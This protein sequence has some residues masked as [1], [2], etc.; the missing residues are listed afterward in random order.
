MPTTPRDPAA[1]KRTTRADDA[2]GVPRKRRSYVPAAQAQELLLVTTIRLARELPLDQVTA[3]RIASEAGLDPSTIPRNFGSMHSLFVAVCRRL[4]ADAFARHRDGLGSFSGGAGLQLF[5]DPDLAL[6][7][8][9]LAWMRAEG[10]ETGVSRENQTA[11]MQLLQAQLQKRLP[12]SDR[13]AFLWMH[14]SLLLSEGLAVFGDQHYLT[15]AD[16]IDAMNLMTKLRDQIPVVESS[17]TWV[18]P[19][20]RDVA[21]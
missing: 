13:A 5:M 17:I 6:R 21:D 11:T 15:E 20:T 4:G 8:R 10:M 1:G 18:D 14:V 7:S 9:I 2:L 3:R 19:G 12:V 16:R